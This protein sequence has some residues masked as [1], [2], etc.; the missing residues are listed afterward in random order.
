MLIFAICCVLLTFIRIGKWLCPRFLL[1]SLLFEATAFTKKFGK[2][3]VDQHFHTFE[4]KGIR[5]THL[6]CQL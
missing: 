6:Q 3:A 2:L 1:A 4:K 5:L